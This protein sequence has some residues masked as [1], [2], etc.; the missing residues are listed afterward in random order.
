MQ[1]A[2]WLASPHQDSQSFT[3]ASPSS[4]EWHAGGGGAIGGG[5]GGSGGHGGVGGTA[6]ALRMPSLRMRSVLSSVA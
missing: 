1:K 4:L 5:S 3:C 6:C 2:Q